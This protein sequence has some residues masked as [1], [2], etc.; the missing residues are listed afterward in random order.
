MNTT[1]KTENFTSTP[2]PSNDSPRR[3]RLS[4][5]SAD[6]IEKFPVNY[7]IVYV[8][9][10]INDCERGKLC[11]PGEFFEMIC[12]CQYCGKLL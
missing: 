7:E 5:Y 2:K 4:D 1:Q 10:K 8:S 12:E 11:K 9:G 3:K 6:E